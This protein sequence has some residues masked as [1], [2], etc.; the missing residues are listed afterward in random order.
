MSKPDVCIATPSF[1]GTFF[2]KMESSLELVLHE[3]HKIGL[4]TQRSKRIGSN[5]AIN[6]NRSCH[7]A[8]DWGARWLFFVDADMM[9]P[10]N[11][12]VDLAKWNKDIVSGLYVGKQTPFVPVA[13]RKDSTGAYVPL[14]S[15]TKNTLLPNLDAVGGG[16][17]LIKTEVLKKIPEPWFCFIENDVHGVL[18]E[19]YYFCAK[20]QKAGFLIH[21]DTAIWCGHLGFY[22]YTPADFLAFKE[23]KE[24]E[25]DK[26]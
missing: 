9:L 15:I 5:I 20:A 24:A 1:D 22:S 6:R 11:T 14:D 10:P 21:L 19:D 8:I 25:N 3:A 23:L 7:D 16:C 4:K 17:L 26:G 12:L 13:S 2:G 18:G